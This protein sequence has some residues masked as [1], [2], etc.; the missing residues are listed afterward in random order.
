MTNES[1]SNDLGI[2]RMGKWVVISMDTL[3]RQKKNNKNTKNRNVQTNHQR[4]SN[5]IPFITNNNIFGIG[6]KWAQCNVRYN[7]R[8]A[9]T[10]FYCQGHE[11]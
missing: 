8:W 9:H 4:Q 7:R 5:H 11:R 6:F 3:E 1:E 2:S 10:D